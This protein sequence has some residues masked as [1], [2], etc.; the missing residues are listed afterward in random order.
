V[1]SGEPGYVAGYVTYPLEIPINTTEAGLFPASSGIMAVALDAI[2]SSGFHS[3]LSLSFNVD[4]ILPS[5]LTYTAGSEIIGTQ[6]EV[7]GTVRDTGI[8]SGIK[9]VVVYLKRGTSVVRLKGGSGSLDASGVLNLNNSAYN[10]YRIVIDNRLEDGNDTGSAGDNDG[11]A[12]WLTISGGVYNWA[13]RFNSTLVSDGKAEVHY[14]AYDFAGNTVS[15]STNAYVANNKPSITSIV[16]GTDLNGDGDTDDSGEKTSPINSGYSATNFTARGNLLYIQVN[17][18]GGNGIRRYSIKH[19]GTEQ[20]GDLT[21]NTVTIDTSSFAESSSANDRFLTILVYDSTT[22]DD[23]DPTDELTATITVGLTIDNV[24]EEAP[25]AWLYQLEASDV[26]DYNAS[27]R[28]VWNGH[29]EPW[30]QSPYDNL[31]S[32]FDKTNEVFGNDADVSGTI[33]FR[34]GAS[35]DQRI[36]AL[37]MWIDL[38]GDSTIDSGEEQQVA[39]FNGSGLIAKS[40]TLGTWNATSQSLTLD[41]G[42]TVEWTFEWDSSIVNGVARANVRIRVR[43]EDARPA[44]SGGADGEVQNPTDTTSIASGFNIMKVD[45][46]PYVTGINTF[47]SNNAGVEFARSALGYFS[48]YAGEQI[49]INGFNLKQNDITDPVIT[50]NGSTTNVTVNKASVTSITATIGSSSISGALSVTVNGIKSI[51]NDNLNPTFADNATEP[52]DD[53]DALYNSWKNNKN[54][55]RLTDDIYLYVW[56]MGYFVQNNKITDP[57]MKMDASSNYYMAYD[58]SISGGSF[59]LVFNKNGTVI[60]I[61]GSYNKFHNNAIAFDGNGRAYAVSTNTDRITDTSARFKFYTWRSTSGTFTTNSYTTN[62]AYRRSLEQVYN[63]TT[64]IYDIDRVPIPK[65]YVTGSN[66]A[67]IFMSYFD[68]N[69]SKNPVKFRYGTAMGDLTQATTLTGGITGNTANTSESDSNLTTSTGTAAPFHVIA[70]DTMT[71]K[72]G[73]YTAVGATSGNVAVVAWY[74]ASAKRLVYSY[75]EQPGTAVYGGAWQVNAKYIDEVYTG[76][77]VD[78]TVDSQN[79]IHI[80]YYNSAKGDLKYAY[81]PSYNC[82]TNDIKIVTVDSY[83]S[84]GTRIS[85]NT[86]E[87]TVGGTTYIVPYISYY[88]ASF[89]QSPSSIRIAWM[90]N[91]I[92]KG[93]TATISNGAINDLFTQ[94]WEVVTIPT[95][96]ISK[97]ALVCNGIP[98]S[99]TYANTVVLGYMSDVGYERAYIQ[100]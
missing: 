86:R 63:D 15:G 2:D 6:A 92:I 48:V 20:N 80:A 13:A 16:L 7:Q 4:N 59:K 74:D 82:S 90:P 95:T 71:I 21:S 1:N 27:D 61:D 68:N 5:N 10:D 84:A 100:K 47:I 29:I 33:V 30:N 88:H 44:A 41:G 32:G 64:G 24:D 22:S 38:D 51:N 94:K 9:Q 57:V 76:W 75:N 11:F 45:V 37:Y 65:M 23:D 52:D 85:I 12:E 18:A 62:D 19:N 49:T 31:N 36:N 72:G 46:V 98:T 55:N 17:A 42:H 50:L 58:N 60:N 39:E 69:H 56:N 87:E 78:L 34:G 83:L 93:G 67:N 53:D 25:T 28:S 3:I 43:A 89:A 91:A 14:V 54:N 70:D 79:G 35:D 40:N 97:D 73:L 96:N 99:G 8:V 66:T 77:F 81:L 26:K